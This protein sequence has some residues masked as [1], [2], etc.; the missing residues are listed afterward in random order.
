VTFPPKRNLFDLM[1]SRQDDT[2]A[3]DAKVQKVLGFPIS[4]WRKGGFLKMM[5]Y[6]ISVK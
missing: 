4:V 3:I 1:F 6:T 2:A 5:P